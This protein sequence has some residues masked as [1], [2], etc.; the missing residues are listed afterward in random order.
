MPKNK[1][2]GVH[3]QV[4]RIRPL[5]QKNAMSK[6]DLDDALGNEQSAQA[7]VLSAKG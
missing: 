3:Y 4:E 6:K 5:A 7:A 1:A 2:I